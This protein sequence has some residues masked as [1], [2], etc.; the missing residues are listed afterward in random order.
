MLCKCCSQ[1]AS[2]FGK[3]SSGHRNRKCQF[4]FQS[5][6]KVLPK[7]AQT[8]TH[9][10]SSHT[11]AKQCSKFSKSGLNS[12][13]TVNFQ[14]FKLDFEKAEESEIKLLASTGS[15]KKQAFSGKTTYSALS[16]A[17][18][19]LTVWIT[20]NC[21]KSSRDGNIRPPD[22]PPEKSVCRSRSKS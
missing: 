4:S 5:Q 2:K 19:P 11:L 13:L 6:R 1:Y 12:K 21:G 15:S 14:M 18:K 17:S 8:T 10:H 22:L 3:L 9:L 16:N 7:N 20:T